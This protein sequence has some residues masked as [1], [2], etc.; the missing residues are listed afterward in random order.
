MTAFDAQ[1]LDAVLEVT[2]DPTTTGGPLLQAVA[3]VLADAA[4]ADSVSIFELDPRE[5]TSR[6]LADAVLDGSDD[7]DDDPDLSRMFWE[8]YPDS[9]CSWTDQGSPW[10]GKY[11][12]RSLLAPETAYP[13]WRAFQQSRAMRSYGRAV[14]LGHYVIVPLSSDPSVTRRALVNRPATDPAFTDEELLMMRLLQPHIDGAVGRALTGTPG[15]ELLTSRELEILAYIR[16][17]RSTRDIASTLW[18]SPATVRKH[19]ENVYAKLGVHS[20]AE[21]IAYLNGHRSA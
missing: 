6:C 8:T 2:A 17:G 9:V 13:T 1:R 14:G 4:H 7:L 15:E 11:P 18:L 5:Q 20:K 3:D 12:A 21:A 16:G 10:F 19:L